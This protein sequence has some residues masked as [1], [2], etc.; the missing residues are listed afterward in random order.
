MSTKRSRRRFQPRVVG[1]EGRQAVIDRF[2]QEAAAWCL[3]WRCDDCVYQ[4]PSSGDC[5][6]AWPN[7]W[8][9]PADPDVLDAEDIPIF[10]KAWESVSD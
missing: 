4:T 2:R 5:S 1:P 6:L 8:L 7:H 3:Q 10:C 9:R